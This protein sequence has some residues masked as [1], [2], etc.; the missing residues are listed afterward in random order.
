[1]KMTARPTD[2]EVEDEGCSCPI[3]PREP[4]QITGISAFFWCEYG[5]LPSADQLRGLFSSFFLGPGFI[6]FH[7]SWLLVVE[8]DDHAK[9]NFELIC[10]EGYA[11]D[12][13][14]TAS[15]PDQNHPNKSS[16]PVREDKDEDEE[17][18]YTDFELV[19][20]DYGFSYG[21]Y[22]P[23]EGYAAYRTMLAK[24]LH[25]VRDFRPPS[26]IVFISED[27]VQAFKEAGL[28]LYDWG[29]AS[30]GEGFFPVGA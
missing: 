20:V 4:T 8:L 15:E 18:S 17:N 7:L 22:A 2:D 21:S 24:V 27:A 26:T 23:L 6:V 1:M 28:V 3:S 5:A 12:N 9:S 16:Q 14:N 10:K 25:F 29:A 30:R 19:L 13:Q 11:K